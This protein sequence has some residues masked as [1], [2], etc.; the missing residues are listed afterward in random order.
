MTTA[1][2]WGCALTGSLFIHHGASTGFPSVHLTVS[3]PPPLTFHCHG[4]TPRV[5]G[6]GAA[7]L[8]KGRKGGARLNHAKP[9]SAS[10]NEIFPNFCVC[11]WVSE[12]MCRILIYQ[13]HWSLKTLVRR[14]DSVFSVRLKMREASERT[15]WENWE[16]LRGGDGFS[17]LATGSS[18]LRASNPF[19]WF[20]I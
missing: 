8:R 13:K 17:V 7:R 14:E 6:G 18:W 19:Y 2:M 12:C 15:E 16:Q 4:H 20:Q 11:Y 10:F 1:G 5:V 3:Q 9:V